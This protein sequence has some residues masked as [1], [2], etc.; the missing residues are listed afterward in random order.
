M[1]TTKMYNY[2]PF[3]F[4]GCINRRHYIL[5]LILINMFARIFS[6]LIITPNTIHI[7]EASFVVAIPTM[8]LH[9]FNMKKRGQDIWDNE[10]LS[11]F[12]AIS[13]AIVPMI[14]LGIMLTSNKTEM[15]ILF[16]TGLLFCII[17]NVPLIFRESKNI[18]DNQGK[19]L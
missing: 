16:F 7:P 10:F 4:K 5:Y 1:I 18:S 2:N 14:C 15:V 6:Y 8:I 11:W 17:F 13:L 3:S 9:M 19:D 12:V